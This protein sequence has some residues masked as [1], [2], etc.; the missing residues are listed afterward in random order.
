MCLGKYRC[1]GWG[2]GGGGG[3]EGGAKVKHKLGR[4]NV[5]ISI[6]GN[7]IVDDLFEKKTFF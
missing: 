1:V 7:V 5:K 3:A 2:G 6:F 4:K